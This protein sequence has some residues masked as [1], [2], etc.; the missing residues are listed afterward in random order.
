ME[1]IYEKYSSSIQT[2]NSLKN[3]PPAQSWFSSFFSKSPEKTPSLSRMDLES[4]GKKSETS[5]LISGVKQGFF[6]KATDVTN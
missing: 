5:S 3:P 4:Q 6:T 1:S 2:T